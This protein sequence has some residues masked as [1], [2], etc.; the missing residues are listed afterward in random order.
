MIDQQLFAARRR[1]PL[2]CGEPQRGFYQLASEEIPREWVDIVQQ[3]GRTF[4]LCIYG[5]DLIIT[6]QGPVVIDVNAFP[7]CRGAI[8]PHDAILALVDRLDKETHRTSSLGIH[9][10]DHH[11]DQQIKLYSTYTFQA[12]SSQ[13]FRGLLDP[14]ML[15]RCLPGCKSIEYLDPTHIEIRFGTSLPAFR[16]PYKAVI[17]IVRSQEPNLLVFQIQRR[18]TEGSLRVMARIETSDETEGAQLT[19]HATIDLEGFMESATIPLRK[20]MT[21]SFLRSF[22]KRVNKA[23]S[24]ETTRSSAS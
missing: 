20:W 13:V 1:S 9:R 4:G 3:V 19:L 10:R 12:S 8:G 11:I 16:G 14:A 7:T 24:K 21:W 18:F 15:K 6:E 5:V 2:E 22:F 23:M 17:R